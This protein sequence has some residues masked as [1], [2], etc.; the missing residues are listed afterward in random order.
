[1]GSIGQALVVARKLAVTMHAILR[2]DACSTAAQEFALNL[3]DGSHPSTDALVRPCRNVGR[4]IRKC[5]RCGAR[6]D[7]PIT[8]RT[9]IA[10]SKATTIPAKAARIP[11]RPHDRSMLAATAR[12]ALKKTFSGTIATCQQTRAG[13]SGAPGRNI[14]VPSCGLAR[15]YAHHCGK[16]RPEHAHLVRRIHWL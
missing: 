8:S 9:S 11:R 4:T 16:A 7:D 5:S 12:A 10:Q 1:M 6:L 3:I 2:S 15:S 13:S 14:R